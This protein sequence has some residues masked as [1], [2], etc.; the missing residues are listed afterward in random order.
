MVPVWSLWRSENHNSKNFS[1]Y[2]TCLTNVVGIFLLG[3]LGALQHAFIGIVIF[4]L[5]NVNITWPR[6]QIT[7]Q[8]Q[9]TESVTSN[10]S[11]TIEILQIEKKSGKTFSLSIFF[12]LKVSRK[13][14]KY[15]KVLKNNYVST[16]KS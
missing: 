5:K 14:C 12:S 3:P 16:E 2:C 7:K 15:L 4:K 9:P 6:Y 1:R 10:Y 8:R 13:I 11:S